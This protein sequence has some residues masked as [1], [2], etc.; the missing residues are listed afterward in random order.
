MLQVVIY[1]REMGNSGHKMIDIC[2]RFKRGQ[3]KRNKTCPQVFAKGFSCGDNVAISFI[4]M[5]AVFCSSFI[6]SSNSRRVCLPRRKKTD[7]VMAST[8]AP[9]KMIARCMF[10]GGSAAGEARR[11]SCTVKDE[12]EKKISKEEP[13]CERMAENARLT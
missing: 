6:C 3:E 4:P 13:R 7:P 2:C 12:T 9:L 8:Q 10:C 11:A 1:Q 5:P